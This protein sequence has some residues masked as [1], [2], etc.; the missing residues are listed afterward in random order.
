M[1]AFNCTIT[2]EIADG[3]RAL[4]PG[5]VQKLVLEDDQEFAVLP[6]DDYEHIASLAGLTPQ[7]PKEQ[8]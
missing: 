3:L 4:A 6:W 5:Q 2:K 1:T 8:P 7:L